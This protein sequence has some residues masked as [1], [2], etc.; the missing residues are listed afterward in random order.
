MVLRTTN[1]LSI[2]KQVKW[3]KASQNQNE[4]LKLKRNNK[5]L[6][7]NNKLD[8]YLF[9]P[10]IMIQMKKLNRIHNLYCTHNPMKTTQYNIS[11]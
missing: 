5:H 10:M 2:L 8:L 7:L 3:D 4:N 9:N 1:S 11:T 6:D